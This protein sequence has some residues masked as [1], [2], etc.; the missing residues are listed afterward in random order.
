MGK[1]GL[2][3]KDSQANISV[4]TP[5][6]G[7]SIG[8]IWWYVL[9]SCISVYAADFAI[10]PQVLD[11]TTEIDAVFSPNG[12]SIQDKVVIVFE[13]DGTT[14]EYE[15]IIDVPGPGGVG[16]PAGQFNVEGDWSVFG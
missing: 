10:L 12:D 13:M 2:S 15:I 7:I 1:R 8:V 16:K 3:C 6:T 4:Q 14:G 11:D 9:C 5:S